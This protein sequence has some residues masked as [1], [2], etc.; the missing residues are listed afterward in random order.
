MSGRSPAGSVGINSLAIS[1]SSRCSAASSAAGAISTSSTS[2][3]ERCVN[4]ENQRSDSI[5]TSNMSTRTARSSVAGKMSRMPPRI[6]NCAPLLHLVGALVP[7][8]HELAGAL[9]EVEQLAAAQRERARAQ[10]GVGHLL[11]ERHRGD[12]HDWRPAHLLGRGLLLP[13]ARPARPPAARSGAPAGSGGIRRSPR[14][15]GSS[16]PAAAPAT[17]AG[18]SPARAPRGRRRPR[19]ASAAGR[20]PHAS[21]SP[22]RQRRSRRGWRSGRGAARPTRTRARPRAPAARRRDRP[23]PG[24]AATRRLIAGVPRS[25]ATHRG[26]SRS[27][28]AAA[29]AAPTRRPLE[30]RP[31]NPI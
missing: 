15:R 28:F 11:R 25:P 31:S 29:S 12:D 4:V 9:L 21:E 23:A 8:R 16:A 18:R 1:A 22:R 13:A 27:A 5:S 26:R 24:P 6:A 3:S 19:P 7:R 17:R 30:G 10:R 14:A 2:P 20:W